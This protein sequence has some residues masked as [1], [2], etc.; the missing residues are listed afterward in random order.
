M[1][2]R[3]A[4]S[5]LCPAQSR[6]GG[7]FRGGVAIVDGR[8]AADFGNSVIRVAGVDDRVILGLVIHLAL[9]AVCLT[10]DASS[11]ESSP[12]SGG[13]SGFRSLGKLR[14]SWCP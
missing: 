1:L 14:G 8:T 2:P 12:T 11:P 5:L 13:E 4:S 10:A 3:P 9:V 7:Q 6:D